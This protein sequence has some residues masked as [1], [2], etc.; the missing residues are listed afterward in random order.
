MGRNEKVVGG[1]RPSIVNSKIVRC[2]VF[3]ELL[4]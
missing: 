2:E 3:A 1:P 4:I